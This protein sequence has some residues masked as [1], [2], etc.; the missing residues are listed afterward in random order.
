M[1]QQPI[2]IDNSRPEDTVEIPV[3]EYEFIKSIAG[4]IAKQNALV[5]QQ[6]AA[7]QEAIKSLAERIVEMT[8]ELKQA[9]AG[10]N[11]VVNVPEQ[12]APVVN[13]TA[14]QQPPAAVTVNIPEASPPIVNVTTPEQKAK[15]IK[16]NRNT[17]TGLAEGYTIE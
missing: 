13:F 7:T 12:P 10:M 1:T 6:N 14:P 15:R 9:I 5:Q 16:V 11:I 2:T 17:R 3:S 4:G 8:E